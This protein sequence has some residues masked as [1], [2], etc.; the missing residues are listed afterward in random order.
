MRIKSR[1]TV[2]ITMVLVIIFFSG[3]SS[4]RA[5]SDEL[6]L[7]TEAEKQF[8]REHPDI[9]FR[10]RSNIPPFEF[11]E[12][13]K[14]RGLAVDYLR[15]IA[16]LTGFNA[17]FIVDDRPLEAAFEE[18]ETKRKDFDTLTYTVKN[19]ERASRFAFSDAFLS[20][21]MMVITH[22]DSPPVFKVTDLN[23]KVIALETSYL[24]NL[25]IKRD[26]PEIQIANVPS[27]KEALQLVNNGIAEAYVGNIAIANYMMAYEG[28]DNLKV[29]LPTQYGNIEYS[30]VAP[31]EWS[32]LTSI[33][34]KGYLRLSQPQHS[35]LQM[36]WFSVRMIE[37]LDYGPMLQ[38]MI[39][40][41]VIIALFI[42][43]NRKL[44]YEKERADKALS[45]LM[46]A[47]ASLE[48]KNAEL[49]TLSTTDSLT[50]LYNRR[51]TE[52]IL[53]AELER[54]RRYGGSFSVILADIDHFKE[55][56]DTYGHQVGDLVLIDIA[57]LFHDRVRKVDTVG[58]WGGEEFLII[59]PNTQS[60]D[61][62]TVAEG[63]KK[64]LQQTKLNAAGYRTVSFGV[65]AHQKGDSAA[66]VIL[67]A[68]QALYQAKEQGRDKVCVK[69]YEGNHSPE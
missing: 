3:V 14:I 61:G 38:V 19:P 23:G 48:Q 52:R 2:F 15:L 58:R 20:F 18:I 1:F 40:A 63:L 68:D 16:D 55:V 28:M 30:F 41:A 10:V 29:A 67:R 31:K 7:F 36:K 9:R 8:I 6:N 13:G 17:V 27:T 5:D 47:K 69:M 51:K 54:V 42:W 57:H 32:E 60:C 49:E 35:A 11:V 56:N 65:T 12:D 26:F 34:N 50:H 62:I 64:V 66:T 22:K 53:G 59:C 33:L 25:W 46:I 4:V 37:K 44:A 39:S 45:E 43:W 24:T 21:P